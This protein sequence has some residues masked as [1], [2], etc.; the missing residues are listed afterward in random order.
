MVLI[1]LKTGHWWCVLK[2]CILQVV[3]VLIEGKLKGFGTVSS[4]E[5][6]QDHGRVERS[7]LHIH[8][9]PPEAAERPGEWR[10]AN[11]RAQVTPEGQTQPA[12]KMECLQ[13]RDRN[14]IFRCLQ[15]TNKTFFCTKPIQF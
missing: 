11:R 2:I 15:S 13:I 10:T 5:G 8:S 7:N 1:V 3:S 14:E 6:G 9:G 12:I 4:M